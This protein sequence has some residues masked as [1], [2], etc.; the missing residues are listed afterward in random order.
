MAICG[1]GIAACVV[2]NK[3]PAV[4]PCL[5]HETFSPRH[6]LEDDELNVICP[7]GLVVAYALARELL[8]TFLSARAACRICDPCSGGSSGSCPFPTVLVLEVLSNFHCNLMIRHPVDCFHSDDASTKFI[9]DETFLQFA[10]GLTRTKY[11]NEVSMPNARNY[12]III[13]SEKPCKLS[14]PA[15]ICRN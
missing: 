13:Y 11:P 3:V 14:L 5:I 6:G 7:G 10:L 4:R 1:N 15:V 2:A 9:F 12:C 8:K